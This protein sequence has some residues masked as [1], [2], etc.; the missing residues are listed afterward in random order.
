VSSLKY[1]LTILDD[2]THYL[3]TFPLKQKSDTFTTLSNFFAYVA[4]QFSC[5]VKAIQCDNRREFDNS[6]TRTFLLSKGAQLWMS[7]PY[8]SPQNGKV[9][10]IIRT[11]NNVIRTL[12]IQ[13]SLPGR[14]WDEGL[15]T[16]VYLLNRLPTKM[17]STACPHVA[18]FVSAPSYEHLRVFGCAYYPNITATAPHK[19]IPQSTRCVF[20]G[21]S[22]N[23]KDYPCF[24]LSTNRLIVSRHVV[25]DKDSFPLAAS[26]NLTDLDFLLEYGS[27]VSTIGTR[28]PLAGST[29]TVAY[30]PSLVVPPGF[31]PLV[32]CNI[33]ATPDLA[34]VTSDSYLGS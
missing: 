10:H 3:W 22:V 17:I 28:L 13:A 5:T 19:L 12:L 25:F 33:P 15:H 14:Y 8:T 31:K 26:P 20:L 32:A 9:E 27:T 2:F 29:T 7:C 18:L 11:I 16:T 23:H 21:Y 4:T 34:I 30:Q 6:F 24:D 1:Y